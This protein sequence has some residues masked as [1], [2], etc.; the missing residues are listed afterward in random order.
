MTR[1]SQDG[2]LGPSDTD[3]GHESR[4]MNE[5]MTIMTRREVP[6]HARIARRQYRCLRC[7][8]FIIGPTSSQKE[9]CGYTTL[10]TL[11][12]ADND[13][14]DFEQ[15]EAR[16]TYYAAELGLLGELSVRVI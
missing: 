1:T 14:I 13:M 16:K 6:G 5:K 3:W 2:R 9:L 10:R 11:I 8:I 15:S 4:S 12:R 7:A